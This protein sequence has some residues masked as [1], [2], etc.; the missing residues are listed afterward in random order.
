MLS[1]TAFCR[2]SIVLLCFIIITLWEIPE[3]QA[4]NLVGDTWA[5]PLAPLG[6]QG[7]SDVTQKGTEYWAAGPDGIFKSTN[8][9][10][11]TKVTTTGLTDTLFCLRWTG[12]RFVATGLGGWTSTDGI[13]WTRRTSFYPQVPFGMAV[14][15]N[16]VVAA[17]LLGAVHTSADGGITWT[18]TDL[19]EN[20]FFAG[21][22]ATT[23][24]F[25]VVG[26]SGAIFNSPD[27]RTW[28]ER[29]STTQRGLRDVTVAGSR[30][31]AVGDD[32][33]VA[34]STDHGNTWSSYQVSGGAG[35]PFT[36]V[37]GDATPTV[38]ATRG[39]L[40]GSSN[41]AVPSAIGFL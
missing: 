9:T 3:A 6:V 37:A 39:N 10:A 5:K 8:L 31:V 16:T 28:T 22:A 1:P 26:S 27:G 18:R 15:G 34:T 38:M 20:Y 14:R 25:V 11:W 17:G 41:P 40:A 19:G 21:V 35:V 32:L 2:H 30:L 29:N 13:S 36:A 4:Q 33:T 23:S 12:T 7:I 24:Q